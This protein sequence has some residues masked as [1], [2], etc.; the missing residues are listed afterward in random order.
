MT[1]MSSGDPSPLLLTALYMAGI[2]SG[3]A[4]LTGPEEW[5]RA[6]QVVRQVWTRRNGG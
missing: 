6:W 1:P 2:F 3:Y 5:Q 4:L